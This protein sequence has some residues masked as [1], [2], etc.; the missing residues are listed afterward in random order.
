[1]T[2]EEAELAKLF[3]NAWRYLSFAAANQLYMMASDRGLDFERIRRGLVLDFPRAAG[4][5][6]AGVCR[7]PGCS[8]T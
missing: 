5:P 3:A 7:R 6:L 4:L 8:R 2:P 1:M